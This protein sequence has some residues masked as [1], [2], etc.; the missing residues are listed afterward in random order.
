LEP[1]TTW[2]GWGSAG[3]E[4]GDREASQGVRRFFRQ[5]T[6]GQ[7]VFQDDPG[8]GDGR[9]RLVEHPAGDLGNG[10]KDDPGRLLQPGIEPD[11]KGGVALALDPESQPIPRG[12]IDRLEPPVDP[13][14]PFVLRLGARPGEP[15][16]ELIRPPDSNEGSGERSSL[17]ILDAPGEDGAGLED[18]L[19]E[20]GGRLGRTAGD[21]AGDD[22][23]EEHRR[24]APDAHG[25]VDRAVG[26]RLDG[27]APMDIG[28]NGDQGLP[29][30]GRGGL[31]VGAGDTGGKETD[32][33][34]RDREPARIHHAA[35]R[36][37]GRRA[38]GRAGDRESEE[39]ERE[40]CLHGEAPRRRTLPTTTA[41]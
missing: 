14:P 39:G 11:R 15:V 37:P 23:A 35:D 24:E 18:D 20:I 4:A 25:E 38:H 31:V 21:D 36:G 22:A 33:G 30:R 6:V 34:A 17:W 1:A 28:P 10:G 8:G 2:T 16:L 41:A 32:H 3:G 7:L 27:E 12:E 40:T 29:G 26:Q 9:A 5:A 19:A 13:G